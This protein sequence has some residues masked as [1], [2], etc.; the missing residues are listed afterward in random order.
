M[1]YQYQRVC[2]PYAPFTQY[3]KVDGGNDNRRAAPSNGKE[4]RKLI[5]E[6]LVLLPEQTRYA[7]ETLLHHLDEVER[8]VVKIEKRMKEVFHPDEKMNLPAAEKAGYLRKLF[9]PT[10]TLNNLNCLILRSISDL[11]IFWFLMYRLITSS[12]VTSPTVPMYLPS[13]Q[14][15]PPHNFSLLTLGK[16]LNTRFAV[17]DFITYN[18]WL[19]L[20]CG[21]APQK[22]CMWSPSKTGSSIIMLYLSLFP[23]YIPQFLASAMPYDA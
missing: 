21:L 20:Y 7:L 23:V 18:T 11:S 9:M 5:Q 10:H 16:L 4:E 13:L 22:I 1:S 12:F 8:Q 2:R 19:G 6:R 15:S 3:L 17:I 14:N